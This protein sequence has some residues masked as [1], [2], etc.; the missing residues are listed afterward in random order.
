MAFIIAAYIGPEPAL[1]AEFYPVN[2][3]NTSLSIAYN[4]AT[5]IFGGTTPY[6]VGYC[7]LKTN[8]LNVISYYIMSLALISLIALYFYQIR[9]KNDRTLT[10]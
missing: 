3:R 10:I 1:Q 9:I 4:L 5:T 2:I 6:I 7:V 8:S